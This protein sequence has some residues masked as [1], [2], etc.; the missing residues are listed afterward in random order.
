MPIDLFKTS[1]DIGLCTFFTCQTL[2]M[3][4][5]VTALKATVLHNSFCLFTNTSCIQAT[6]S[7]L[8]THVRIIEYTPSII[9]SDD[10]KTSVQAEVCRSNQRC[11]TTHFIPQCDFLVWNIPQPQFAIQ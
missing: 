9:R 3:M 4:H 10:S 11:G 5:S 7:L 2:L 6:S 1:S 8:S